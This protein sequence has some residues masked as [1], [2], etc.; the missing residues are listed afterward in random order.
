[1]R[2]GG[3]VVRGGRGMKVEGEKE[4]KEVN[5]KIKAKEAPQPR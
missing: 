5:K 1:M 4:V 3:R 2:G